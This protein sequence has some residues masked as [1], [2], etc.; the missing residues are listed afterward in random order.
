MQIRFNLSSLEQWCREQQI[1]K[2]NEVVEK[3]EPIIQATKLLQTRKTEEHIQTIVEMCNKLRYE[4]IKLI[5]TN[6]LK[7]FSFII[8]LVLRK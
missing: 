3:L 5:T 6:N 2:W 1:P 8:L 7:I 4:F